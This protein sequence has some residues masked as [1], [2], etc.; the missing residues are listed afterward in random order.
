VGTAAVL[1]VGYHDYRAIHGA[2]F[3][4][5][6][7]L[8]AWVPLAKKEW[9]SR[10]SFLGLLGALCLAGYAVAGSQWGD[11]NGGLEWGPRY[12]LLAYPLLVPATLQGLRDLWRTGRR[13][14]WRWA[15]LGLFLCLLALSVTLQVRGGVVVLRERRISA[16]RLALL[17][18]SCPQDVVTDQWWLASDMAA[19]FY[20]R[21]FYLLRGQHDLALWLDRAASGGVSAFCLVRPQPTPAA[22]LAALLPAA[23]VTVEQTSQAGYLTFMVI[24]VEW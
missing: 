1:V 2:L 13:K 9:G 24:R 19:R 11:Y 15:H 8:L 16:E 10:A 18:N 7:L 20:E 14:W 21:R 23:E 4:S 22:E 17:D 12:V 6:V 5:P 3:V